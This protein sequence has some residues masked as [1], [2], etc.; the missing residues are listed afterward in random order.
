VVVNVFAPRNGR[1]L[2]RVLSPDGTLIVVTPT[3]RHLKQLVP[4]LGMLGIDP[5]K[6]A[7]VRATLSPHLEA[8][9]RLTV[10]FDMTLTHRDVQALVAMGPSARHLEPEGFQ[11]AL[12]H[13]PDAVHVTASVNVETFGRT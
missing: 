6:Q 12:A 4:A 3:P 7:R 10:E 5:D 11:Q 8:I 9:D 13:L 1:E 2:A